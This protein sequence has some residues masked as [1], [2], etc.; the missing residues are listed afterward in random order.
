[1]KYYSNNIISYDI[2]VFI[3]L[4]QKLRDSNNLD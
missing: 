1:M 2:Y 4:V 3:T